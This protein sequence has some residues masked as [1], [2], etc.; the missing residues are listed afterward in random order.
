MKIKRLKFWKEVKKVQ[1]IT[2]EGASGFGEYSMDGFTFGEIYDVYGIK[3]T[4]FSDGSSV[5]VYVLKDSKG[6]LVERATKMFAII[7]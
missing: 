3:E 1:M 2:R 6:R 5:I 7:E 4:P